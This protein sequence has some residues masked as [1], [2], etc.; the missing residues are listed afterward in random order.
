MGK[1]GSR[2][3][4]RLGVLILPVMIISGIGLTLWL[5]GALNAVFSS[6]K[7][8]TV[9][10]G[11]IVSA[12][13]GDVT[14]ENSVQVVFTITFY[15]QDAQQ[16]TATCKDMI[17]REEFANIHPGMLI[18]I[19]YDPA[20][21]QVIL[22]APDIDDATGDKAMDQYLLAAGFVTQDQ[23]DIKHNGVQAKAVVVSCAPTGEILSHD[24]TQMTVEIKVT[25]PDGGGTYSVT[26]TVGI[27][28]EDLPYATVG[29]ILKVYYL[30]DNEQKVY[31]DFNRR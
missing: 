21:P 1:S 9:A 17:A 24:R 12:V 19:R 23:L 7:N 25:K 28:Q 2:R 5:S 18:S 4:A 11:E 3:G 26:T 14:S 22:L 27:G 29:S 6:A 20:K 10:V 16:V 13:K 31:I 30:P 8:G 15:T